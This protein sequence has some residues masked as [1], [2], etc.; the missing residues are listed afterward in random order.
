MIIK[1]LLL[2]GLAAA[3]YTLM[4]GRRTALSLLVRRAIALLA[5]ATGGVAV[6]FPDL[7]TR[8]AHAVG[9]G[10]G[11][12]LVVYLLCV[13]FLFTTIGLHLRL[14]A[15]H[16]KYVELARQVALGAARADAPA[17]QAEIVRPRAV[18]IS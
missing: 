15:M 13:A 17:A 7:V 2:A 18:D 9:V 10:R 4:H 5:L 6:L 3:A 16:D 8:V 11:T 14:A 12:D 1:V